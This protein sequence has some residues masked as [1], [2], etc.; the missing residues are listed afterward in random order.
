MTSNDAALGNGREIDTL[1]VDG[2]AAE[3]LFA[4]VDLLEQRPTLERSLTQPSASSTERSELAKRV[5]GPHIGQ[6]ALD[7]VCSVVASSIH[8]PRELPEVVERRSVEGLLLEAHR[9]GELEQVVAELHAFAR[10]VETNRGLSDALRNRGIPVVHRQALVSKLIDGKVRPISA[11]LLRRAASGR[12]RTLARSVAGYLD[13][14]AALAQRHSAHVTVAKPLDAQRTE[15]LRRALE[16]RA[17]G[18]VFL[19]I[20]VDP[21]VLGGIDVRIG[22]NIIESTLAGRLHHARRLLN[23]SSSKV[24]RNG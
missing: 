4:V 12:D 6:R 10:L 17:G 1:A 7:I 15:R 11:Q 18:P 21:A 8:D 13:L 14:A 24:G 19:Q 16:A 20:D 3:E 9:S 22:E 5:F 2:A 23:T